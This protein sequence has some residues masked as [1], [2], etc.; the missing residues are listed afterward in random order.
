LIDEITKDNCR[1]FLASF[2]EQNDIASQ[3][4]AKAITCSEATIN[5]IIARETHPSNEMIKQVGIMIAVGYER[6][7]KLSK[8]EKEKISETIG[9][10]GGGIL[11]FGAITAAISS[12]GF[13]GLSAAG[14]TSGLATLG[15]IIGGGMVAGISVAAAIP[16]AAGV[17]GYAIIKGV[18]YFISE[19]QLKADKHDL[20]WEISI[21]DE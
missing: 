1:I 11:G 4:I 14:V 5:R 9:A 17:L 20:Y 7:V 21:V 13:I 19:Q 15:T 16:I 6:Y 18:K 3:N 8:A 10:L 12:L 2:M